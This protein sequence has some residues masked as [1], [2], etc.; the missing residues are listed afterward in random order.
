ME[1]FAERKERSNCGHVVGWLV[2]SFSSSIGTYLLKLGNAPGSQVLIYAS[3]QAGVVDEGAE[4]A[5]VDV[6]EAIALVVMTV[7]DDVVLIRVT[8]SRIK[9][10]S[11]SPV[12]LGVANL[13]AAVARGRD[14]GLDGENVN[15]EDVAARVGA[16]KIAGPGASAT[17][18]VEDAAR[19]GDGRQVQAAL[20]NL[21]PEPV[22]NIC[23]GVGF[24]SFTFS[25]S[26][27][28]L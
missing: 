10:R 9:S 7:I 27:L 17:A 6:V 14:A 15:A 5:D 2:L 4:R 25:F 19:V 11:K 23:D 8:A 3:E 1:R 12:A 28:P 18:D 24:F 13:E 21:V 16:S 26:L 22:A 20:E